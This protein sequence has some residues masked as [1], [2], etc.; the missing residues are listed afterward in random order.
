[1]ETVDSQDPS[2]VRTETWW[3]LDVLDWVA[4]AFSLLGALAVLSG[5]LPVAEA[6][7]TLRRIL[8]LLVF[9]G[10]VVI[11]A[12]LTAKAEVFN[13]IA[14]RAGILARG[15]YAALF[16]L[17]VALA[18]ATTAFLNLDTTAVLLTP[19][20]L[21]IARV[22]QVPPMPL[23]ITTVWL[24]N[25]ASLL[26]PVSN[27]TNLLAMNRVG[28]SAAEFAGRMLL[29]Q[30]ASVAVTMIC[31]WL[32]YWRR[33][34]RHSDR[35]VT[36]PPHRP[37]DRVLFVL[38]SVACT[39]FIVLIF[40]GVS[41]AWTTMTCSCSVLIGFL[42]RDRGSL[43]WGLV[44]VRLLGFVAGLFLVVQTVGRLGLSDILSAAMSTDPGA[45]GTTRAAL[46]GAGMSNLVNNLP[47]YV[48]GEA[49]IPLGNHLQLLG[50]LIG[51]NVGP[52]VLPWASLATLLWYEGC[53]R[54]GVS[55]PW[56]RF[57]ATGAVT[58]LATLVA[59]VGALLV[60]GL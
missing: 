16:V 33:G 54:E 52:I 35:Y 50:L 44:P 21:A 4:I 8:P 12:E 5:L 41:L 3:R 2:Q 18:S 47:S 29:P 23:A 57:I 34:L 20:M 22:M 24:A 26:L 11:L 31:L 32:F 17:C 1:M 38:A 39:C 58:A 59:S 10:F 42:I 27:L 25:T 55:V 37:R 28:V 7:Q 40:A 36:P 48:A 49:A 19:V 30:L 6:G 45:E 9:L 43:R 14:A 46:V 13:V 15:N 60:T 53:R 56:R 51:T